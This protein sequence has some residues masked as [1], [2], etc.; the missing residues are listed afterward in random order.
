M[1]TC[2]L[3]LQEER[4]PYSPLKI[5]IYGDGALSRNFSNEVNLKKNEKSLVNRD[6]CRCANVLCIH[7][8]LVLVCGEAF[9]LGSR[10]VRNV[11]VR[12]GACEPVQCFAR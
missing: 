2:E 11:V 5:R 1:G 8:F 12:K 4:A 10:I 7:A 9:S 3:C 6:Y